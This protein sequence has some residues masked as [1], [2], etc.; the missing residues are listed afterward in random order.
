MNK[1][2]GEIQII[3]SSFFLALS[4][5]LVKLVPNIYNSFFITTCRFIVGIVL[6]V[7][8]ILTSKKPLKIYDIKSLSLRGTFGTIAMLLFYS[9]IQI[10]GSGRATLLVNT[11]P[12]FVALFGSVFFKQKIS[13]VNLFSILL[14][15]VGVI[16]V[17]DQEG[18]INILG[19][20]MGLLAAISRGMAVLYMKES[21]Q[22]NEPVI[23][24][25]S[26][27]I[28]GMLLSPFAFKQFLIINSIDIV[29]LLFSIG[30]FALLAQLLLT[31]GIKNVNTLKASILTYLTIPFTIIMG[32][33][34]NEKLSIQFFVGTIFILSG[35]LLEKI[36]RLLYGRIE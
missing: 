31:N 24:Y 9:S 6:G 34:L 16:F 23:V 26:V 3:I 21:S 10:I 2:S 4:S 28:I 22:K 29:F 20:A 8:I 15:F 18:T 12:I 13:K 1:L 25:L 19:Y 5:V 17:F 7:I 33:F 11:F 32:I 30:F 27:C 35:L 14:C 36:Y